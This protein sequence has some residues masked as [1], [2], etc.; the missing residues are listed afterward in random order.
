MT[1]LIRLTAESPGAPRSSVAVAI[2][3]RAPSGVGVHR[4]WFAVSAIVKPVAVI[5]PAMGSKSV[6]VIV[7][8]STYASRDVGTRHRTGTVDKTVMA[9][10]DIPQSADAA[11][12]HV[13]AKAAHVTTEAANVAPSKSTADMAAASKAAAT[14]AATTASTSARHGCCY[15]A[16]QHRGGREQDDRLTQHNSSFEQHVLNRQLNVPQERPPPTR[17]AINEAVQQIDWSCSVVWPQLRSLSR[18]C[19]QAKRPTRLLTQV[20]T[21]E[22]LVKKRAASEPEKEKFLKISGRAIVTHRITRART[23]QVAT[24]PTT[25]LG[26]RRSSENLFQRPKIEIAP[27]VECN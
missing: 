11:H 16:G 14:M 9:G 20:N 5:R 8:T 4:I 6:S 22:V 2:L 17:T 13:T 25:R 24:G 15:P 27:A 19:V 1:E 12:S 3:V 26:S 21:V 23:P 10:A 18:C 7:V